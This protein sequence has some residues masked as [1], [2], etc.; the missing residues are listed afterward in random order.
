MPLRLRRWTTFGLIVFTLLSITV[1]F[2]LSV[3]RKR[4]FPFLSSCTSN[5][6]K[7][8]VV[9]TNDDNAVGGI[10]ENGDNNSLGSALGSNNGGDSASL[11]P[12]AI[13]YPFQPITVDPNANRLNVLLVYKHTYADNVTGLRGGTQNAKFSHPTKLLN[14]LPIDH[15]N[16]YHLIVLDSVEFVHQTA[17]A[18]DKQLDELTGEFDSFVGPFTQAANAK[19]VA[20]VAKVCSRAPNTASTYVVCCLNREIMFSHVRVLYNDLETKTLPRL[21]LEMSDYRTTLVVPLNRV[22]V[23]KSSRVETALLRKDTAPRTSYRNLKAHLQSI[24]RALNNALTSSSLPV[25]SG[26]I[27]DSDT[28]KQFPVAGQIM[29]EEKEARSDG[30]GGENGEGHVDDTVAD[31]ENSGNCGVSCGFSAHTRQA[32]LVAFTRSSLIERELFLEEFTR[33]NAELLTTRRTPLRLEANPTP[34][35]GGSGITGAGNT[36]GPNVT[37]RG[38]ASLIEAEKV[39]RVM[40]IFATVLPSTKN[41]AHHDPRKC[42][43]SHS[44]DRQLVAAFAKLLPN[45]RVEPIT[46]RLQA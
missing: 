12:S 31:N 20:Y 2:M 30:N 45:Y 18:A 27:R 11:L 10:G 15:T 40:S 23:L 21:V 16:R 38:D 7:H 36:S 35:N 17:A 4:S 24:C 42:M 34:I 13:G 33:T 46:Y 25:V 44:V 22:S 39:I 28:A 8:N 32:I 9:N 26:K 19:Y 3:N 29:V 14:S 1:I 43:S 6:H 5:H 41:G 37:S